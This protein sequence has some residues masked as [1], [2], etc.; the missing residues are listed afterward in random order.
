MW[1]VGTGAHDATLTGHEDA[2]WGLA[3]NK[4]RLFSTSR[5]STI[6]E[7]AL[8]TWAAVRTVE[9]YGREEQQA[10]CCL[11]V[12]GSKLISGSMD[13]GAADETHDYEVL[14]WDLET[15]E[16]KRTLPQPARAEVRSLTAGCTVV[17][18]AVGKEVVRFATTKLEGV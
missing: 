15:L 10:P 14:V 5:D 11:A 17:W 2:V 6:R 7:W 1:D 18:G 3:V 12:S 16:C 8:G 13:R 4:D 9:A